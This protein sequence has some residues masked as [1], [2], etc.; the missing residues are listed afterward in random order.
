MGTSPTDEPRILVVDDEESIP[1][2]YEARLDDKYDV[3][4]AYGG[5]EA[6]K[7]I[8]D[9]VDVVTLD[10]RMPDLNGGEVLAQIRAG[11]YNCRVVMVTAV[12]PAADIVEMEFDDYLNKPVDKQTLVE[13][14]EHQ[15]TVREYSET[16]Q[17]LSQ[18]SSKINALEEQKDRNELE[19]LQ[20]YQDLKDKVEN[21]R[22][23]QDNLLEE[24]DYFEAAS[25]RQ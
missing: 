10:R 9:T 2:L 3:L 25:A 15:L 23:Q 1:D 16:F 7:K 22:A 13:A 24:L 11:E 5:V 18:S 19:K 6:T 4:K 20:S 8:D 17:E 21:L 14:I 12:E